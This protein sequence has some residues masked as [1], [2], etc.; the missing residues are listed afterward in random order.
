MAILVYRDTGKTQ[1]VCPIG[2]LG[3]VC[4]IP[5]QTTFSIDIKTANGPSNGFRGYQ[6]VLQYTANLTLS[7]QGGIGENRWPPCSAGFEQKVAGTAVRS[8]RYILGCK[9]GL[10]PRPFK[11]VLANIHFTCATIGTGQIDIVGGAGSQ[12]SF[13][14]RPGVQGNRIFLASDPKVPVTGGAA[15]QVA[16]AVRIQCGTVL[17]GSTAG[18]SDGD[19]CDDKREGGAFETLGGRRDYRNP[20]DFFDPTGDGFVRTDDIIGVVAR[21]GL[22]SSSFDYSNAYDRTYLGPSAWNL[23]PPDGSVGVDDIIAIT[24]VYGHRCK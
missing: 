2:P 19:S 15:K 22:D 10:K 13:Y 9:S 23:G 21:Y 14:D 7:Q 6:I 12:V 5:P 24:S 8:P 1:L 17:A 18:D 11:G 4:V 3:R 20:W 16:D